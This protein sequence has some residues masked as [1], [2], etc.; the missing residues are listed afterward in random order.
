[1]VNKANLRTSRKYPPRHEPPGDIKDRQDKETDG[2]GRLERD[3]D[4]G[5]QKPARALRR[6]RSARTR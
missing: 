3:D 4:R 5:R 6:S 2:R 1:M